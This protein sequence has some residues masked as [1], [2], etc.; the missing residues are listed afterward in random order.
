MAVFTKINKADISKIENSFKLG[1][2]INYHGIKKGIE[3]TNYYIRFKNQKTVL[4][5]FEK[6]V[7]SKDLPFFM[8]LMDELSKLKIVCPSP[9]KNIRGVYL[10]K[11]RN[12]KACLV[13]FLK[14]G[15][16]KK[17]RPSDLSLIHI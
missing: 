4:T 5:I 1:K 9:I 14:G 15:D 11:I 13:T 6:R 17:L 8:N 16:K 3:N 7:N 10:F 2:I 12:K